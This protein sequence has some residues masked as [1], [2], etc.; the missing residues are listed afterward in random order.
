MCAS[1]Y[2]IVIERFY[3]YLN[4]ID[5]KQTLV[6]LSAGRNRGTNDSVFD[7][8][9]AEYSVRFLVCVA[10]LAISNGLIFIVLALREMERD[11]RNSIERKLFSFYT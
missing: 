11:D 8:D 4:F 3:G 2:L 7:G 5:E 1:S 10:S 9:D 6:I